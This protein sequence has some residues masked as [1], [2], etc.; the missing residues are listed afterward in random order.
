MFFGDIL[1]GTGSFGGKPRWFAQLLKINANICWPRE[2]VFFD[3]IEKKK[4]QKFFL[5]ILWLGLGEKH[6]VI[7]EIVN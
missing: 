7:G 1:G 5:D 6:I 2:N 4:R 3:R